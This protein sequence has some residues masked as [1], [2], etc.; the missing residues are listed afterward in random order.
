[1]TTQQID[2]YRLPIEYTNVVSEN[3]DVE[4]AENQS[5]EP[6]L[7]EDETEEEK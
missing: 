1:M 7:P 2:P 6:D 3:P 5:P 4:V